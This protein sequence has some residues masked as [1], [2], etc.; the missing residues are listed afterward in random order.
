MARFYHYLLLPRPLSAC[1][2]SLRMIWERPV[3][4]LAAKSSIFRISWIGR[5]IEI[6][7]STPVAGRPGFRMSVIDLAMYLYTETS[8]P[9]QG[10]RLAP[11]LTR[12]MRIWVV[13]S[14]AETDN[15]TREFFAHGAQARSP[16]RNGAAGDGA[17]K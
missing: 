14:Q 11:A 12:N 7:G 3:F 17:A 16:H 9:K 6:A 8:E 10:M 5:R 1:S 13:M 15:I 2:S 4:C